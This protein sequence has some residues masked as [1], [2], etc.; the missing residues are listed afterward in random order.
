MNIYNQNFPFKIIESDQS[1]NVYCSNINAKTKIKY[2]RCQ[3]LLCST[4]LRPNIRL[5]GENVFVKI[6]GY[7]KNNLVVHE[8]S[9]VLME[10]ECVIRFINLKNIIQHN[11]F[12]Q[13]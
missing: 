6:S 3:Q 10:L 12:S 13:L 1:C 5:D 8:Y 7:D 4:T 9:N 2:V 11:R